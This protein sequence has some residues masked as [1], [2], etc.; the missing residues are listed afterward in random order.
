[1]L[2]SISLFNSSVLKVPWSLIEYDTAFTMMIPDFEKRH[3][4]VSGAVKNKITAGKLFPSQMY[5]WLKQLMTLFCAATSWPCTP[6][7]IAFICSY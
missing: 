4:F 3:G 6:L 5:S 1:M 2:Q 7:P